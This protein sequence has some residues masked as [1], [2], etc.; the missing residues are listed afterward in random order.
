MRGASAV[1]LRE[2]SLCHS[3]RPVPSVV[4]G[5][6]ESKHLTY[7]IAELSRR[8]GIDESVFR[9]AEKELDLLD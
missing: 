6:E 7:S 2:R 1:I 8:F 9:K 5:S 3:E 4:E